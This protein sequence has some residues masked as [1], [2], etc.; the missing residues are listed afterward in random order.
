MKF[1]LVE[2][3]TQIFEKV[4]M[5]PGVSNHLLRNAMTKLLMP[6]SV[7]EFFMFWQKGVTKKNRSKK[8]L[9]ESFPFQLLEEC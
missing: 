8:K 6:H 4:N 5:S 3:A 1:P 9:D 7:C 2:T